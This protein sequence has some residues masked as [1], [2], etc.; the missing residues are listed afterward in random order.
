MGGGSKSALWRQMIADAL[1]VRV[2]VPAA[3]ET[4]ALGGAL[5]AVAMRAGVSEVGDDMGA[6]IAIN[7]GVPLDAVVVPD[8]GKREAYDKAFRAYEER[9]QRL[10]GDPGSGS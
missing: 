6:W 5:Q 4:A 10:F 8:A 9:G 2:V 3:P 1:Q 7:H